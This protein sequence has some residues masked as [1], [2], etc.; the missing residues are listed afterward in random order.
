MPSW[1]ETTAAPE[2]AQYFPD[3]VHYQ[4]IFDL[5]F[6]LPPTCQRLAN[7]LTPI[8]NLITTRSWKLKEIVSTASINRIY[9]A[10]RKF[11][12]DNFIYTTPHVLH[13][14]ITCN[15][16]LCHKHHSMHMNN[17]YILTRLCVFFLELRTHLQDTIFTHT[18]T[19]TLISNYST[20]QKIQAISHTIQS[21]LTEVYLANNSTGKDNLTTLCFKKI[22]VTTSSTITWTVSVRL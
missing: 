6:L 22:H 2:I 15:T 19:H 14:S 11:W 9:S 12:H 4:Y 3:S 18:H 8:S 13:C 7:R 17:C 16:S 10:V 21:V 20:S 1:T 5:K